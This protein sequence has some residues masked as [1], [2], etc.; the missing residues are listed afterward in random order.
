MREGV[1]WRLQRKFAM[2]SVF[3]AGMLIP[4]PQ[5]AY[6]YASPSDKQNCVICQMVT[7]PMTCSLPVCIP[8]TVY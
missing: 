2:P 4:A 7:A 3:T 6:L 8:F 1:S 5:Q